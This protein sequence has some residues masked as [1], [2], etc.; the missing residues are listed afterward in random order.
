MG[1]GCGPDRGTGTRGWPARANGHALGCCI[2]GGGGIIC[3]GVGFALFNAKQDREEADIVASAGEAGRVTV[4]TNMAGRGRDI[5]LGAGVAQAGG[6][7]VILT[8]YHESGRTDRQLVGRC[9]RQGVPGSYDIIVSWQD[10]LY[11]IYAP[12]LARWAQRSRLP[13]ALRLVTRLAQAA[14]AR[15]GRDIRM[16][17]LLHDEH[18]DHML[19]F[20]GRGG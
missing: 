10:D 7:Y 2:R 9:S 13:G 4:A 1:R 20:A 18:M 15:R 17:S 8:E 16:R 12:R 3:P 5:L 14:A 19:A 6:L 11:A